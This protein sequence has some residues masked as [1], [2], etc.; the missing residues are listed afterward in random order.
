MTQEGK[1]YHNG[2]VPDT[3]SSQG[4]IQA[5]WYLW[6][7][8]NTRTS[9]PVVKSSVQIEHPN[10]TSFGAAS[11]LP[12]A[13]AAFVA[14]SL[15]DSAFTIAGGFFV[16]DSASVVAAAPVTSGIWWCT[17]DVPSSNSISVAPGF[18][19][20]GSPNLTIGKVSSIALASPFA[21]LCLGR[22][23][24][25]A[26]GP[27]LSGCRWARTA[28][29]AM[30]IKNNSVMSPVILYRMLIATAVVGG[31]PPPGPPSLFVPL[32]EMLCAIVAGRRVF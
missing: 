8:G 31:G 10:S 7:Q 29:L 24:T 13:S 15:P 2:Q 21:R 11:A 32:L 1:S 28:P 5:G 16:W 22:P 23:V 30:T 27:Y 3:F 12:S 26:R 19:G 9:S 18:T 20:S 17:L 4:S 6:R 25:P 14:G